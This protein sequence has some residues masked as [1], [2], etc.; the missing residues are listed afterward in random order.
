MFNEQ[1]KAEIVKL[2]ETENSV[3][4]ADLSVQFHT[5]KETIRKDLAELE[6][7][8]VLKRTHGG[9]VR[10]EQEHEYPI[11][12]RTIRESAAKHAICKK[13]AS[14]VQDG[15]TLFVDN[16]STM[17]YLPQYIPPHIRLT[18]L[19]NSVA[20]LLETTKISNH[21]WLVVSLGGI[22]NKS[23]HSLYG[24]GALKAGEEYYPNKAFFSCAGIS[25]S[26]KIAD[27]SLHEIEI[28]RVMISH[29]QKGYLLADA[30]KL[31]KPGQMRLCGFEDVDY[32]ITNETDPDKV[33]F[34]T[35]N[36]IE[37]ILTDPY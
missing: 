19:T 4:V 37:V 13:A 23:N 21:N 15:D 7:Q 34:L 6:R 11:A 36:G 16:S 18:I 17:L 29:S 35:S 2:I 12:V 33:Q 32:L 3:N 25:E 9:A 22:F 5:S 14:Y 26:N 28:K 1:R 30:S 8:G 27:S 24:L 31:N 10:H 20:F